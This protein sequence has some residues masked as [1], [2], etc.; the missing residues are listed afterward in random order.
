MDDFTVHRDC[1][2][3][4]S[5]D[6]PLHI[7]GRNFAVLD[8]DDPSAVDMM[9]DELRTMVVKARAAIAKATGAA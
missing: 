9:L 3:L 5:L 6:N 1:Y 7:I 4:G 8:G 2:R